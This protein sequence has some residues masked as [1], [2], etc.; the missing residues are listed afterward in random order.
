MENS[1]ELLNKINSEVGVLVENKLKATESQIK[2]LEEKV[3][4]LKSYDDSA[5]KEEVVKVTALV[6]ALKEQGK[7]LNPTKTLKEQLEENKGRLTAIKGGDNQKLVLKVVGDMSITGNVTGEVPQAQ[8]LAGLNTIATRRPVFV[9]YMTRATA[10]SNLISWVYQANKDGAAGGTSEGTAKNK[11]DFDLLVGSQQVVKR[12]ALVR[13][14]DEMIDDIDFIESEIRN[15]LVKELLKDV[16]GT[17][18]SG[19]NTPPAMNG[20]YTTATAFAAGTFAGT[21]DNPNSVDVLVVAMNQIMIAEQGMPTHIFMHPSDVTALKLVKVTSTDKRYVER[22]SEI[23]GML[24]MDGTPIVPTTLVTA[25]TFLIGDMSRAYLF[26]KGGLSVE[27]G[28]NDDDFAKNFRTIRAEWRGAT[29]VKNNDRT[30]FVKG[31]FST[32]ITALETT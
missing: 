26:E 22:L 25:G 29:V 21:V 2:S 17:A 27:I 5:I 3:N 7:P 15:E 30:A 14:T 13:V 1:A 28:Y 20:V 24:S 11:I 10:S 6:E 32:A 16:E 4:A 19:N 12:T 9:D 31:T 18:F 23:G 8:R